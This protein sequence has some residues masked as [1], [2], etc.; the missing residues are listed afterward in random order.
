MSSV[1][2]PRIPD[3][4]PQTEL[5]QELRTLRQINTVNTVMLITAPLRQLTCRYTVSLFLT[6]YLLV[7]AHVTL[8]QT[9]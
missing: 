7:H 6:V 5:P 9:L 8:L 2:R 3:L 1:I 4:C